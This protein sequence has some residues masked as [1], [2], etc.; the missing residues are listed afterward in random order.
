MTLCEAYLGVDHEF[1]IWNYFF[2]VQHPQEL[3]A[4]LTVFE[5][6]FPCLEAGVVEAVVLPEERRLHTAPY[7]YQYLPFSPAFLG[8]WG[9]QDAPR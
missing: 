4:E 3:D 6:T 2:R 1:D 5:G 8:G 7:V 9:D